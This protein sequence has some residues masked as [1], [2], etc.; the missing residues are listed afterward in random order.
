MS[1]H[2]DD[3]IDGAYRQFHR[4][5][6]ALRDELLAGLPLAPVSSALNLNRWS[7][8]YSAVVRGRW[9]AGI[10]AAALVAV[11]TW[12]IFF[13]S[14]TPAYALDDVAGRLARCRSIDVEGWTLMNEVRHPYHI[15]V[16]EPGFYWHSTFSTMDGKTSTGVAGSDGKTYIAVNHQDKTVLTGKE[17]PLVAELT[18][19]MFFQMMLPDQLIGRGIVGYKKVGKEIARGILSDVYELVGRDGGRRVIWIDQATGLPL[20]SAMYERAKGEDEKQVMALTIVTNAARPAQGLSLEPPAGYAVVHRDRTPQESLGVGSATSGSESAGVLL[21]LNIDDR[22]ILLCWTHY[23]RDQGA[24][25]ENDL[26]GAVGRPIP[27]RV[28][29]ID[30]KRSYQAHHL[31]ADPWVEGR[32]ARWSLLVPQDRRAGIGDTCMIVENQQMHFRCEFSPLRFDR[33][34]LGQIIMESQ[35]LMLSRDTAPAEVF[36]LDQLLTLERKLQ[37]REQ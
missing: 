25:V 4:D 6:H 24:I 20:Q 18:T 8:G 23:V 31:R 33:N 37:Q 35:K 3:C 19:R 9:A 7:A 26:G 29:S 22:A 5:H 2:D 30:G 12:W 1:Q 16:E 27:L 13:R 17:I 32:H 34:R 10:A 14:F 15:Y 21:A 11:T 36:N 28:E